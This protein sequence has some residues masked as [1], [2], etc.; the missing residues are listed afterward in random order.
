MR[1]RFTDKLNLDKR[2]DMQMVD[3]LVRMKVPIDENLVAQIVQRCL[4]IAMDPNSSPRD[5]DRASR[6][7]QLFMEYNLKIQFK[8]VDKAFPDR[9]EIVGGAQGANIDAVLDQYRKD[10]NV[11]E[12]I[13]D[14][15]FE[16]DSVTGA[17]G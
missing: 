13:V 8:A 6:R 3:Q 16:S 4:D 17:D 10:P 1:Q 2:R 7:I 15:C 14:E 12:A 9:V 5:V 11:V